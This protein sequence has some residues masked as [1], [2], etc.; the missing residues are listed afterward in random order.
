MHLRRMIRPEI[1]GLYAISPVKTDN[2]DLITMTQ[3]VLA[4]GARLFQYRNKTANIALRLEQARLLAHL[5]R[6]FNVPFIVNDHVDLAEEIGADGVHLGQ[7]DTSVTEARHRLGIGKIIGVS[8]YDRLELSVEAERQGADYVAFGAF[9]A[10]ITKPGATVA[11]IDLLRHA[12]QKLRIPI[13]VIGGIT[14]SNAM[15]LINSGAAAV[16]ASHALFGARNIQSAT[17]K[18]SRLFNQTPHSFPHSHGLTNDL[19]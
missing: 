13:V 17:E 2:A 1:K 10:S 5:C 9:Y 8:C 14:S 19:T 16:A 3:Q 6:E 15:E 11:S 7:E 12:K 18:F 4:G